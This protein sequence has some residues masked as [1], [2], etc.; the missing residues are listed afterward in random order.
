[1]AKTGVL[2]TWREAFGAEPTMDMLRESLAPYSVAAVLLG[3]SRLAARLGTWQNRVDLSLDRAIVR[4]FL[5]SSYPKIQALYDSPA[6]R[7]VFSRI[8]LLFVA[9]QALLSCQENGRDATT[10]NDVEQILSCCLMAND[11]LLGRRPMG[12]DTTIDKVASLLPFSDYVS[13]DTYPIDISRSLHLIEKVA[14]QL[15]GRR[16]FID[17]AQTFE[18]HLGLTARQ[19]CELAFCAGS[20]FITNLDIQLAGTGALIL[21]IPFFEHTSLPVAQ[22]RSFLRSQSTS[23][24]ALRN[25]VIQAA[26]LN[27]DFTLFQRHPLIE[28]ENDAF[29][30]ID[31]GFLLDKGGR[32]LFWVLLARTPAH[33]Q[34]DLLRY[35]GHVVEAY[36]GALF[37][38]TYQGHGQFIRDPRFD[39]GSQAGDVC[40][41]EGSHLMIMEVKAITFTARAKYGFDPEFLGD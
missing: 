19:F 5:P 25:A 10:A 24:T 23:L 8:T 29:L 14:P 11:L 32:S 21:T 15:A 26:T 31:P 17:I 16:D 1:M 37:A 18:R 13:Q 12:D 30:C 38:R 7:I 33:E 28:F 6:H 39:D 20:K 34:E 9:K 35:W 3:I 27:N 41:L 36:V 22:V 40:L 2:I 4:E